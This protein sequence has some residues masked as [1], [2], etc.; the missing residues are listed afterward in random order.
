MEATLQL[1]KRAGRPL[2]VTSVFGL[3]QHSRLF[4][5]RDAHTHTRFLVHTGSEVSIIPLTF[6]D[7]KHPPAP[8][9]LTAVNNTSIRMYG[10][11]HSL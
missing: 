4:Y 3:S 2:T 8:R 6:A 5:A 7:R 9:T 10:N 11:A 1:G